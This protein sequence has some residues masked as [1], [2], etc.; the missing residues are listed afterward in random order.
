MLNHTDLEAFGLYDEKVRAAVTPANRIVRQFRQIVLWPLQL[1]GSA[2]NGMQADE[3]MQKAS[4]GVWQLVEDEFGCG[5]GS[6]QERHYREFV[7][8]LP[9]VQ[10]FLY[11]DVPGPARG[12]GYGDAPLKVLRRSDIK[13]VRIRLTSEAEPVERSEDD[14]QPLASLPV[15]L[16]NTSS[17][18]RISLRSSSGLWA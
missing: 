17:T 15:V 6:F 4:G 10:R 11:G 12:L 18:E 3:L 7:S 5:D 9:H 14:S 8:F 1:V 13:R 2:R 16:R